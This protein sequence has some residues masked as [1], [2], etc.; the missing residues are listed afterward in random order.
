MNSDIHQKTVCLIGYGYW[1]KN[2]LRN[3]VS[4]P[5]GFAVSLAELSADKR[6][7][8]N[9]LYPGVGVYANAESCLAD[10]SVG[11]IVI[12]TQTKYHYEIAR[13]AL[14]NGKH[15]LIEK[16]MTTSL[17]QAKEL[18]Q[19]ATERNLVLM[20]DH[21]FRYHPVVNK[22]KEYFEQGLLG[23]I[24][25]IDATRINLGIYQNDVNVLWDLACHDISIIQYLI[26]EKPLSVRTI[27]RTSPEH[28]TEDLTYLFLQY[29]SGLLVQIN[30]SWSSPVKMRRM[31]VGGDKRMMLYDDI[32][33]TNKLV[34]YEYEQNNMIDEH[35]SKL[36]D[37]RLGNIIIPKFE[38]GEALQNVVTEF[39]DCILTG[40][41]PVTD[42][43]NAIEVINILE[44][45][46]LS[47]TLNGATIPLT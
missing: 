37:Y 35:K 6:T 43:A 5:V 15:V 1:G 21:I 13:M 31:I 45:A 38:P 25:Y 47:L 2:L 27:G 22:M 9:R 24:N 40:R 3:M 4:S 10:A 12:A 33:P 17:A 32:E 26:E 18:N 16:P 36:T 11:A 7:A 28:G 34:I 8:A 14:L 41:Q 20:V 42:G 23:K 29:A 39:Y 19:I 46:Q 30:S 44:K